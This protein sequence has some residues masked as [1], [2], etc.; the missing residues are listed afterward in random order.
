MPF[1]REVNTDR[2]SRDSSQVGGRV[3][4][5]SGLCAASPQ[6][7]CVEG[8]MTSHVAIGRQ[9]SP[10]GAGPSRRKLGYWQGT[11]E[12]DICTESCWSLL[13]AHHDQLSST[14]NALL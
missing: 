12:G 5:S 3:A 13:P 10:Q 4:L 1:I 8:L 11:F 7:P 2:E 6:S 14:Q 9:Q